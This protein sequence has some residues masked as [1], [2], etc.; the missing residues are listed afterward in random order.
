MESNIL[1]YCSGKK[2]KR[3]AQIITHLKNLPSIDGKTYLVLCVDMHM[4]LLIFYKP[5]LVYVY[6]K[7]KKLT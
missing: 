4:N 3:L 6:N 5:L 7:R 2:K 1:K